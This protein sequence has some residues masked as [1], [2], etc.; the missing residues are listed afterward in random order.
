M[1]NKVNLSKYLYAVGSVLFA[2]NTLAA[3][4]V[5]QEIPLNVSSAV[6][7][8]ILVLLDDSGSMDW[9]QLVSNDAQVVYSVGPNG[10]RRPSRE[11]GYDLAFFPIN[12]SE[13]R[14][15]CVGYNVLAYN[16]EV[17]YTPWSGL[18]ENDVAYSD[19]TLTS[20]LNNPYD[21]DDTDDLT[22][23]FYVTWQDAGTEGVFELNECG[24]LATSPITANLNINIMGVDTLSTADAGYLVDSGGLSGDYSDNE[25]YTFEIRPSGATE[26][27][28][29]FPFFNIEGGY[30]FLEIYDGDPDV[31]G[32]NTLATLT[33]DPVRTVTPI[34]VN[35]SSVFVRFRSDGSVDDR[36]FTVFWNHSSSDTNDVIDT[37]ACTNSTNCVAISSLPVDAD[38]AIAA[39][40]DD[41]NTQENYANWYTYYRKREYVAKKALSD[42]IEE[43]DSRVGLATLHNNGG[44]GTIIQNMQNSTR[45]SELLDNLFNVFSSGGTP[46]RENLEQAGQYFQTDVAIPT[47]L[48]GSPVPSHSTTETLTSSS[49]IFNE[50]NGGIC[51]QNYSV[52]F[53]DGFWNGLTS[54]SVGNTDGP[55]TGNSNFD[56]GSFADSV[57]NTLADVAM[58]YLETDLS[59]DSGGVPFLAN[60]AA[61][62]DARNSSQIIPHQHMT[63]YS[64]AFGVNG[65]LSAN[66]GSVSESFT[67]PDPTDT[68]DRERIDDMRHAAWNGR[69]EFL[70]AADP[71]QLISRLSD[72]FQSI[73]ERS[74]TASAA[75]LSSGLIES[76]T[77]I[78]QTTFDIA[79]RSGDLLA[80]RFDDDG[81]IDNSGDGQITTDDAIWNASSGLRNQ[82]ESGVDNRNIIAYNSSTNAGVPFEFARLSANRQADLLTNRLTDAPAMS[83]A[84]YGDAIVDFLKG[85]NTLESAFTDDNND[86][87]DDYPDLFRNR[88]NNYL[89]AII[90][91][92]PQFIGAPNEGYPNFIQDADNPY[93]SFKDRND[94]SDRAVVFVGGNGG[95]LHAFDASLSIDSDNNVTA[96]SGAG[97]EVFAYVPS[98]LSNDL[99]AL[100]ETDYVHLGYVDSTPTIRDVFV[101]GEWRTF[102]V[103]AVRS[104][105]QGIYALDV[106]DPSAIF[107]NADLDSDQKAAAI[108]EFEYTH[109]ELGF[110]YSR[111]QIAKMN[112]GSWVAIFGN[113]Y[114]ANGD[115]GAKLF[116]IDLATGLPLINESTGIISVG[117]SGDGDNNGGSCLD[118]STVDGDAASDCNG[119]SSPAIV[120]LNG[121]FVVDRIYAGDLHGNMWVFDVESDTPSDWS[122][123]VTRLFT[124]CNGSCS[125]STR[126][127]ITT[128]PEIS[129]HPSRRSSSTAPNI[130]VHFGTGQYIALNDES[131][132]RT[133]S[134]YGIW[135]Y[136]VGGL[137]RT[138][139]QSRS[140]ERSGSSI[141]IDNGAETE[142]AIVDYLVTGERG[143]Y[144]DIQIPSPNLF[145]G[146]RIVVNSQLSGRL[147]FFIVTI[148]SGVE[149]NRSGDSY[150]V[151]LD[152]VN[153]TRP[154]FPVFD[155]DGDGVP[156]DSSPVTALNTA[157]VGL[158]VVGSDP[159]LVTTGADGSIQVD[160]IT[161]GVQRP[162]GRKSW[163][164]L[165]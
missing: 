78:F 49:P 73:D 80:Y 5:L 99:H 100:S 53:S 32:T 29:M 103:G 114:N 40:L 23:H 106:T 153:G 112:N 34:T 150:R 142:D 72:I 66:P 161:N 18:N 38:A 125:Q 95:M 93:R 163:S 19:K 155:T 147:I 141:D 12:E 30:D 110:T 87:V 121:D 157:A 39:G 108:A 16:P 164:I 82:I 123:S 65:S 151:V 154:S 85:D 84:D 25:S 118:E 159:K 47:G 9:E 119:L 81:I 148:P 86:T 89:Q 91:S 160:D 77:L 59:P 13:W 92:S 140:F 117:S 58:H 61:T 8:N 71:Q 133:Q 27:T 63:T 51:Q 76:D 14:E 113:G 115:G 4:G 158:G 165:R 17:S 79:N 137:T 97:Q 136:G 83:E 45:K 143:W 7:P 22:D 105:G 69:G 162:P 74:G 2:S 20:A 146:G 145:D 144:I 130:L 26:I 94:L 46:L 62:I 129:L 127:P 48:F 57:S 156:D 132:T 96:G 24:S 135:D 42:I 102:L 149:C 111:P 68:E 116:I 120:D 50:A 6:Q 35:S 138:N 107:N 43:E 90:N 56:G 44:V 104:G 122:N 128:K 101:G 124:A 54:P 21:T 15:L 98:L 1:K 60:N 139:L 152:A 126:Q 70:S 88:N 52:V 10:D 41:I 67:W 33:G 109:P 131:D 28:L 55:D 64:I 11:W 134:F 36:G 75:S 3:P 31:A 37:T